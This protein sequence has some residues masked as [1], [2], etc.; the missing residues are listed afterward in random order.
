[1]VQFLGGAFPSI[2]KLTMPVVLV[3][4]VAKAHIAAMEN[5]DV[6]NGNRYICSEGTYW[7]K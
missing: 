2:P 3:S 4:D 6:S 7:F 1:M 5:F